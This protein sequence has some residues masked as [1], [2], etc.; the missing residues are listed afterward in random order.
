MT[1]LYIIAAV[2][3]AGLLGVV[4]LA[5][6]KSASTQDPDSEH[7]KAYLRGDELDPRD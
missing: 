4:V 2:V 3:F 6:C 5:L 7:Y 1:I